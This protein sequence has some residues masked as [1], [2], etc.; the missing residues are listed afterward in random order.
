L[1]I[2]L[3]AVLVSGPSLWKRFAIDD[4]RII[5]SDPRVHTL[6]APW[7][8]FLQTYWPPWVKAA[9]YRPLTSLAFAVEWRI[10]N[11]DPWP[12]H[13]AN[14]L[15]YVAVCLAVY[16]LAL[17]LLGAVPA[18]W[19]AA[20]F[21]VHPVHVEAVGNSVGQ[22]E[23]WAGLWVVLALGSYVRVRS[24]RDLQGR[25]IAWI[26][27]LYA[28]GC[29][30]KE[31]ALMLPVLMLAA[32]VTV[33]GLRPRHRAVQHALGRLAVALSL[34]AAGFWSARAL[35]I[36]NF[37]G[38][39]PSLAFVGMS[40]RD[41]VLT[42]LGVV[43][44]WARLL[45]VPARL[46]VDY[47]PQEVLRAHALDASQLIGILILIAA[48]GV[49]GYARRARPVLTFAALWTGVTLFPVSNLILVSGVTL[50]ERTLFLPSVGAMLA[51]GVAISVIMARVEDWSPAMRRGLGAAGAVILSIAAIRSASRH[52]VWHDSG[53]VKAQALIDSPLSYRPH[54]WEARRLASARDPEGADREFEHA[55]ALFA[56]D[57]KLLEDA[58]DHY[59]R[60]RRC[61][62]GLPL[63][64]RSLALAPNRPRLY[65]RV[66]WCLAELGRFD[67]AQRAAAAALA[68]G[69][70]FARA[71]AAR[72]DSLAHAGEP[73]APPTPPAA[74]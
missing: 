23:L 62:Q 72:V 35:V 74:P 42:M 53:S 52:P 9:L 56:D 48:I 47:M 30:S 64:R 45:F 55:L 39:T 13:A 32:E 2:A 33:A 17:L 27:T 58:A 10:G 11:G 73:R 70:P 40:F 20:L 49:A 15:V 14:V 57:P 67:E 1:G 12:Y 50:A 61:R 16:R 43:P 59:A 37:A 54:W 6:Q 3:L 34:V 68:R 46:Q 25:D 4:V 38:D 60:S 66:T 41:R 8:F 36:G 63:Y 21:A 19:A 31:H 71:D 24:T 44:E 18:W 29:L 26:T 51:L 7:R 69:D 65:R 28:A 22:A 5:A